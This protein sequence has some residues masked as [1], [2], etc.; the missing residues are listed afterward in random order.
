MS[1]DS[2]GI[3][4]DVCDLSVD[5]LGVNFTCLA[6]RD[7]GKWCQKRVINS[8]DSPIKWRSCNDRCPISYDKGT[9]IFNK[10]GRA[11]VHYLFNL[12]PETERLCLT[13]DNMACQFP[14]WYKGHNKSVCIAPSWFEGP[15]CPTQLH[16]DGTPLSW[17]VCKNNCNVGVR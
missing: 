11:A 4:T 3:S 16:E 13:T 14:Y 10:A 1:D 15:Q 17:G 7:G 6:D 12:I 5:H 8:S 9:T 2:Y